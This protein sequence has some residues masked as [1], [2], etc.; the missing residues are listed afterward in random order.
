MIGT[1]LAGLDDFSRDD[2]TAWVQEQ[3]ARGEAGEFYCACV[4]CCVTASRPA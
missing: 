1:Y 4:Q 3:M 2:A